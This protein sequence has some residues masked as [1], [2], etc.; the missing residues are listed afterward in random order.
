VVQ[1][2]D[3][4]PDRDTLAELRLQLWRRVIDA[5][6]PIVFEGSA[7]HHL[8]DDPVF[9]GLKPGGERRAML[10]GRTVDVAMT[11]ATFPV[12]T[13][14]GSHL[15]VL[16]PSE[17][18]VD[19]LDAAARSL[20]AQ[21][22]PGTVHFLIASLVVAANPVARKLVADLRAAGHPT[23]TTDAARLASDLDPTRPGY[24]VAFGMEAAG[25]PPYDRLR[26]L[27]RD[28][29]AHGAHLVAWWRGMRRF[30][31]QTG[32][33]AGRAD[34]AGLVFLNLPAGDV[35]LLVGRPMQW[36]PRPNRAL[37]YDRRTGQSTVIVPF[38]KT[39]R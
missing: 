32:G 38:T 16:G 1:F 18:A 3:P 36:R 5:E 31:E 9:Q 19:V 20:A 2:P 22:E 24:L 35:D 28:G 7:H 29:P 4:Y 17:A 25:D 13:T 33:A 11:T 15:A 34:V 8:A 26:A 12:D 39:V 6:P 23:I 30:T 27:V 10:I 37:F 21:H 14:P